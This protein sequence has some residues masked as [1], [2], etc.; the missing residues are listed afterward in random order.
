MESGLSTMFSKKLGFI[1]RTN[2]TKRLPRKASHKSRFTGRRLLVW[3]IQ[4]N[5]TLASHVC[6]CLE[7]LL[8]PSCLQ[9]IHR[10]K[11]T[12]PHHLVILMAAL[13]YV[14]STQL[15][16]KWR[17]KQFVYKPKAFFKKEK[18]IAPWNKEMKL[19]KNPD[20]KQN[21]SWNKQM[22]L[23]LSQRHG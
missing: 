10:Y 22:K 17:G 20:K 11:L 19:W 13:F 23:V 2:Q 1:V 15:S 14:Q 16:K 9:D 4:T 18:S 3:K 8:T 5:T 21:L 7:S 12:L 6:R